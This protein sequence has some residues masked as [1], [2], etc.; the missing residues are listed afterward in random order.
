MIEKA[1]HVFGN[2]IACRAHQNY[3]TMEVLVFKTDLTDRQQVA[4]AGYFLQNIEGIHRWNVDME[5][6]DNVLRVEAENV[7]PH[8][9]SATLNKAGYYCEEL[10]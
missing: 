1:R 2:A 7:Q 4:L 6:V 10:E 3:Y 8:Y 5:D 9:V